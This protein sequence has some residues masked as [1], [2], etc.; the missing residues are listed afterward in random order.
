[1]FL[2][3]NLGFM[4]FKFNYYYLIICVEV[5]GIEPMSSIV[6]KKSSTSLAYFI[7]HDNCYKTSKKQLL[8]LLECAWLIRQR[9]NG[10][11]VSQ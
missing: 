10:K 5:M 4:V 8:S 11:V 2:G 3:K 1:L 7:L 9:E 6:I